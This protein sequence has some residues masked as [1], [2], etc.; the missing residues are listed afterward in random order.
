V[1]DLA[2][3]RAEHLAISLRDGEVFGRWLARHEEALRR[4]LAPFARVADVEA[5][6][7]E[8]ALRVWQLAPRIEPDGKPDVL[9]RWAVTVAR[10][11]A[12]DAARR[13]G[14][15]TPIDVEPEPAVPPEPP[16]DA[17]LRKHIRLCR[18]KLPAKPAAVIG[19]RVADGGSRSDREL[20]AV[21]GMTFDAF[22][23]N[24]ARARRLLEQC[25]AGFG[26]DLRGYR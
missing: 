23:Q 11:L 10:N 16:A 6:L 7:Q 15:E 8:T 26:I 9:F 24:L 17:L 19:A 5:I 21:L 12:R 1:R 18:E 14:R 25:L 2:A 13:A 20:A 22:R 3:E 4:A